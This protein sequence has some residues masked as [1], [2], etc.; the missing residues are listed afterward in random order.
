MAKYSKRLQKKLAKTG[1]TSGRERIG[2]KATKYEVGIEIP[3]I[4]PPKVKSPALIEAEKALELK[5]LQEEMK[6]KQF[7][8]D[9]ILTGIEDYLTKEQIREIKEKLYDATEDQ[10]ERILDIYS[11]DEEWKEFYTFRDEDEA[12]TIDDEEVQVALEI[13]MDILGVKY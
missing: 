3:S 9:M 10:I 7:L 5:Q 6:D 12:G 8:T 1:R 2:K 4:K 13:V 11:Q